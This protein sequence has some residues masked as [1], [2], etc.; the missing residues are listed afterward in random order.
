MIMQLFQFARDSSPPLPPNHPKL[1]KDNS[2]F[3]TRSHHTTLY[4]A[5]M[6]S[7]FAFSNI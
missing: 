6:P 5:K 4:F 2:N 7:D 3:K 1:K